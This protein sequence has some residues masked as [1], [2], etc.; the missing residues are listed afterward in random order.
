MTKLVNDEVEL[1]YNEVYDVYSNA[2]LEITED[3]LNSAWEVYVKWAATQG[4]KHE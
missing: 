2:E 1:S 3:D 4:D